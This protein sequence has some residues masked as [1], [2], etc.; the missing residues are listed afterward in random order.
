MERVQLTLRNLIIAVLALAPLTTLAAKAPVAAAA[1]TALF[2][3]GS[4]T[5][6]LVTNGGQT[7]KY[8][9]LDDSTEKKALAL[10][11]IAALNASPE[12]DPKL[13]VRDYIE[14]TLE[15]LTVT[16]DKAKPEELKVAVKVSGHDLEI[17]KP[18]DKKKFLS[19][20]V[21]DLNFPAE[22]RDVSL[23]SVES[24]GHLRF[25]YDSSRKEI[26]VEDALGAMSYE[27]PLSGEGSEKI[28]FSGRG[29]RQI[30]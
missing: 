23:F 7:P 4:E 22:T 9:V 29:I 5:F 20:Q 8:R 12:T 27:S 1:P 21:I 19:G 24:T 25:R 14:L 3:K 16:P 10:A 11:I 17:P 13:P 28:R 15:K 2:A 6:N 18:V 26:K 30:N